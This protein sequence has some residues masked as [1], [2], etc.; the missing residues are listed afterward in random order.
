MSE[1]L[2]P[3]ELRSIK[4]TFVLFGGVEESFEQWNKERLSNPF[5]AWMWEHGVVD[6]IPREYVDI[7]YISRMWKL[8]G[9]KE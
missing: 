8:I 7:D 1:P 9:V 2:T 6:R 4:T 5:V 3:G